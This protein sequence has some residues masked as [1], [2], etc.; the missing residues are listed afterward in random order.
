MPRFFFLNFGEF[1]FNNVKNRQVHK[2]NNL[3]HKKEGNITW[4]T[5]QSTRVIASSLQ[6]GRQAG[7]TLPWDSTASQEARAAP[8]IALPPGKAFPRREAIP[9]QI[10]V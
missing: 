7:T 5:S 4:E 6:A 10:T 8:L 1:R 3:A 9:S 2:F